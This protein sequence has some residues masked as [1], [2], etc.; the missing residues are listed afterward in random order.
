MDGDSENNLLRT[1][2]H[3]PLPLPH[4]PRRRHHPIFQSEAERLKRIGVEL[5]FDA[6]KDP[7]PVDRQLVV[8]ERAPLLGA[9]A[10]NTANVVAKRAVEDRAVPA[11]I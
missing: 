2:R 7:V 9:T 5:G 4:R 1:N 10:Q 3:E 8:A 6:G 11:R